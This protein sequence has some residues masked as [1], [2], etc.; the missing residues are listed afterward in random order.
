MVHLDFWSRGL[1]EE[2][3]ERPEVLHTLVHKYPQY[4]SITFIQPID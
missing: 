2:K 3:P 1:L 4:E